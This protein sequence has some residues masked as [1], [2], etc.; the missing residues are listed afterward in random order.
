MLTAD[1]RKVEVLFKR[2][3]KLGHSKNKEKAAV[4]S[5]IIRELSI[6]AAIEE[7]VLYP[8]ARKLVKQTEEDVLEALEEHHVVK[9]TIGALAKMHPGDERYDAKVSV[10]MDMVRHHVEEE[11]GELFPTLRRK[12]GS[13][14]LKEVGAMLIAAKKIA[15]TRPH[16][17]APDTP[18]GN[19]VAGVGAALVD[20]ALDAGKSLV[21]KVRGA[22]DHHARSKSNGRGHHPH[23]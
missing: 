9:W 19:L 10:L 6:H 4:V 2:L 20:R 22:D 7:Q 12:L 23:A 18:P 15:P 16:P 3:E 8:T 13:D 11:E 14:K 5:E 1:H 17:R 21:K